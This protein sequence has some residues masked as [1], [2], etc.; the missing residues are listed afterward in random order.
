MFVASMSARVSDQMEVVEILSSVSV[1]G[2]NGSLDAPGDSS[3]GCF[4]TFGT[5]GTAG[6]CVG[7]FGTFGCYSAF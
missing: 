5:F 7:T 1:T 3:G 2:D 4:G 6:G